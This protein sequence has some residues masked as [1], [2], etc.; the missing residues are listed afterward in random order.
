MGGW[1]KENKEKEKIKARKKRGSG[2][3]R[4][5]EGG[6]TEGRKEGLERRGQERD[7]SM[8]IRKDH[9]QAPPFGF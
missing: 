5:W 7:E 6:K 4:W 3:E 9:G 1:R 2:Q 8:S